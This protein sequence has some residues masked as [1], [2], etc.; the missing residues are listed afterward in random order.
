M[1]VLVFGN[2]FLENDSLPLKLL[3][4]LREKFPDIEFKEID[5][6]EDLDKQGRDL[7]ILDTVEG[8]D[9]VIELNSIE[10]LHANKVYS[11][12]DFDLAYNLK[13]LKKIGKIDSVRIIGVPM[14]IGEGEAMREIGEYL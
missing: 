7:I 2:P 12:H 9:R 10:Q 1:K 8:I 5:P 4:K 3:P 13:L 11:M 14:E 6:T